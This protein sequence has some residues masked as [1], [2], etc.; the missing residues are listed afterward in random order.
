MKIISCQLFPRRKTGT[1]LPREAIRPPPPPPLELSGSAHACLT[2]ILFHVAGLALILSEI[3]GRTAQ[4][5]WLICAF[6]VCI[7]KSFSWNW[8]KKRSCK[9]EYT[10]TVNERLFR[11]FFFLSARLCGCAGSSEPSLVAC[12]RG[13][14]IS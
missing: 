1:N 12:A 7:Q 2:G 14:I 4:V 6:V 9:F 8:V 11:P 3:I 10:R 13:T 5:C